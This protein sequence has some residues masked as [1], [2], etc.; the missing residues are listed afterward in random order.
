[1]KN[2]LSLALIVASLVWCAACSNAQDASAARSAREQ[3]LL[4]IDKGKG[5]TRA[6]TFSSKPSFEDAW[7][8][9]VIPVLSN[10]VA[11]V[12]YQ[13]GLAVSRGSDGL[14]ISC[15][16]E[17]KDKRIVV[18]ATFTTNITVD[19]ALTFSL[20]DKCL[21]VRDTKKNVVYALRMPSPS[22]ILNGLQNKPVSDLCFVGRFQSWM[23]MGTSGTLFFKDVGAVGFKFKDMNVWHIVGTADEEILRPIR[24]K[25]V[26]ATIAQEEVEKGR[27]ELAKQAVFEQQKQREKVEA[28]R[29]AEVEAYKTAPLK[30]LMKKFTDNAQQKQEEYK[31]QQDKV[32]KALAV[33]QTPMG[34][35][36][37]DYVSPEGRM[38]YMWE[39]LKEE[40][41]RLVTIKD[42]MDAATIECRQAVLTFA[43]YGNAEAVEIVDG[44]KKVGETP[45]T[46][47]DHFCEQLKT[48][49]AIR[50]SAYRR[51]Y[52]KTSPPGSGGAI[53]T[54]RQGEPI[55]RIEGF[56]DE[57]FVVK[58]PALQAVVYQWEYVSKA[59]LVNVRNVD[60]LTYKDRFNIWRPCALIYEKGSSDE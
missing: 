24:Q 16:D 27:Q 40:Q 34:Q 49:G 39:N 26:Q 15:K 13:E 46:C 42:A 54:Y 7:K 52:T 10:A 44:W 8:T 33:T 28:S 3:E 6:R 14:N 59:G 57:V 19:S 45:R 17:A 31:A 48:S 43:Q 55:I 2:R 20:E 47:A 11:V 58:L 50:S 32:N 30:D 25:E 9:C 56:D 38:A 37:R 23:K 36:A 51:E 21:Y 60:V 22:P 4:E 29:K 5:L 12:N 41:K 18:D 1:M 53:S 35:K